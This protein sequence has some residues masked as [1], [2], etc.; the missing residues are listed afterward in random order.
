MEGKKGITMIALIIMIT[1]ILILVVT[2]TVTAGNSIDNTNISA[3]AEDINEVE[4]FT[5][6]YYMQNDKFPLLEE[7]AYN[8]REILQ[9]VDTKNK[10]KFVEE[11]QLNNDDVNNDEEG[12]FY[13]IDLEKIDVEQTTRGL[14]KDEKGKFLENDVFVVAYPSMNVYYL[15]GL[16]AK[17]Q[18][19]FSLSSKITKLTQIV[20]NE[21]VE[22]GT[23]SITT[24]N[25]LIVKNDNQE[26]NN[27][28]NIVIESNM[29]STEQ[30]FIQ[31]EGGSEHFI[32]TS[33]GKNVFVLNENLKTIYSSTSNL[34]IGTDITD[35][36][37][38]EFNN[39]YSQERNII[40]TKQSEGLIVAKI[41][42]PLGK[43]ENDKP[44]FTE[45]I[46]I[47]SKEDY[48]FV[49]FRVGDM[50][51]GIKE[52]RYEYLSRINE[53]GLSKFYYEG[54]D[55]F[56]EEYMKVNGKKAIISSNNL[57]E[58]KVPK[59][60]QIIQ[61][62]IVD[63]AGNVS[64]AITRNVMPDVYIGINEEN[65][66]T[67]SMTLNNIVRMYNRQNIN[68]A[69]IEISTDGINYTNRQNLELKSVTDEINK[70]VVLCE[71][72]VGVKDKIYVKINV[73]YGD[74]LTETRVK[75]IKINAIEKSGI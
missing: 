1:I 54:I 42:I 55:S 63:K 60:I 59:D 16:N 65:A 69:T 5:K 22:D 12:T 45:N 58:I 75:E 41:I 14:Q 30:L 7:K 3:F 52:V 64:E 51:S 70:A 9:M 24:S 47:L 21:T 15:A 38:N 29:K 34:Q 18:T 43:Y 39:K 32:N 19:F 26:W 6:I 2:I 74:N 4:E 37:I 10:G 73:N 48:N 8:R 28:F 20:R 71:N 68:N 50:T 33:S 40:I 66:T 44:G 61:I 53:S 13:K 25:G 72:L 67:T 57:V 31:L 35:E 46:S 56:D 27:K 17:G 62:N 49:T 36:E 11:L 23:T